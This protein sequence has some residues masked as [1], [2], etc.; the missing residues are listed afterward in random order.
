MKYKHMNE[1]EQSQ[2]EKHHT[3]KHRVGNVFVDHLRDE[4]GNIKAFCY[5]QGEAYAEQRCNK[6]NIQEY[7]ET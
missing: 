5:A 7:Q 6:K 3:V 2:R 1:A 4:A